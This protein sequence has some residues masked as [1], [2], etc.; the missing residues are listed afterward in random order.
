MS[1]NSASTKFNWPVRVYYE[2]T[3]AAGVVYHTNYLKFMERARTEWL[4][5]SGFSQETLKNKEGVLFAVKNMNVDFIKPAVLD[6]Q[7]TVTT[8][9]KNI[10]GASLLFE[11]LVSNDTDE[12]LCHAD[13]NVVCIN[14][15]TLKPKRIPE[16]IKAK[17]NHG[18]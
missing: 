16:T 2:D 11:Q 4:R 9:I 5:A 12:P 18:E 10:G 7:L 13:V 6:Q 3:D 8:S 14:S 15:D 17:I 1:D